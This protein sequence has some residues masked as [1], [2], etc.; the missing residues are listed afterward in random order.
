MNRSVFVM[1]NTAAIAIDFF[2][3]GVSM[4]KIKYHGPGFEK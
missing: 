2:A 1:I 3:C 4:P